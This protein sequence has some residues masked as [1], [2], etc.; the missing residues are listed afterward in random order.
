MTAG[1]SRSRISVIL[2]FLTSANEIVNEHL[3]H[4]K[5]TIKN[6][7]YTN[8]DVVRK[9]NITDPNAK[10]TKDQ[11]TNSLMNLDK[12]LNRKQASSISTYI[13]QNRETISQ[14]DF[15]KFLG[16]TLKEE[17]REQLSKW[18]NDY[19]TK[20]HNR[21]LEKYESIQTLKEK[22]EKVDKN[23]SGLITALQF[24]TALRELGLSLEK[25]DLVKLANSVDMMEGLIDYYGF[26]TR[27]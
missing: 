17:T 23:Y 1:S 20:L 2:Y 24:R 8:A 14:P 5:K 7:G 18:L 22:F 11:I 9:I 12:L 10:I 21:I 25:G 6:F 4:V 3:D 16:I 27:L 13:L 19:L 26:I 15:L